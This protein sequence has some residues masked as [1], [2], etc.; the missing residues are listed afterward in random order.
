MT[1]RAS[2]ALSR[3]I[4]PAW[5]PVAC[6]VFALAGLS[7]SDDPVEPPPGP[8]CSY[9]SDCP[10]NDVCFKGT[11]YVSSTCL[12]R[13]Q[14]KRVPVCEGDACICAQPENRCIPVCETDNDC[15]ADG[16]C[17]NGRCMKYPPQ[18]TGT[19][20]GG[21]A[22][23]P[24]EIGVARVDLD[25]PMGVSMAGFATRRGP[26]TP[27]Q[28]SLGGSDA[29][30][31][32]PDV[33]AIAL[34]SGDDLVVL[35]RLPLGW[36][37]ASLL[38]A[39]ALEVQ[40][41]T[42][43]NLID[44]IVTSAPHSHHQPAR[45]W[46][47]VVGLNFGI[48]GYDEFSWE[49]FD[50]LVGSFAD[51]VVAALDARQPGRFGWTVIDDFDPSGKIHRDRRGQ[52]NNLPG[53][54]GKD[55]RML[56]MRFDDLDGNPLALATHFAVHGTIF[57][58]DNPIL[59]G[60]APGGAE[61]TLTREA[62][63]KYGRPVMG[64]FLQGNAGDVSPGGD[65]LDHVEIERLQLV[66]QRAWDVMRDAFDTIE[67]KTDV[68]VDIATGRF[69]VS[70]AALGYTGN[71]FRDDNVVCENT[72]PYFRY[73]SFQCM[74][75]LFKDEDPATKFV[76]GALNCI[77]AVECLTDGYPI[78]QFMKTHLSVLRIGDL[79]LT[80][81]PGEPLS[82]FGMD[83][84][85]AVKAKLPMV[86]DA[87]TLGYSQDHNFYL[88]TEDDW[89]QGGY[90]PSRD[91]WGWKLA[92]YFA[93]KA[94]FLAGELAKP[95][96]E[97][98]IDD[99]NLKPMFWDREA[100]GEDD[101]WVEFTE[102][103]GDPAAVIREVPAAVE[104]LEVV[105]FAWS[106]GH[107]GL[108][109]PRI[110]LE[111]ETDGT[112]APV[113][114]ASGE[115]YA[116]GQFETLVHY[117]GSC[118]REQCRGHRWSVAW[119]EARDF[120]AGRYRLVATGKAWKSGAAVEYT[121]R[122]RAFDLGPSSQLEVYGLTATAGGLEGRVL[123][124]RAIRWA[125]QPDGVRVATPNGHRMRSPLIGSRFAQPLPET[126]LTVTATGSIRLP[127][128]MVQPLSGAVTLAAVPSEARSEIER[129][130]ADGTRVSRDVG[131]KPTTRF[132]LAAPALAQ[133]PAGAYVV[134]LS[135]V[136]QLGNRGT[137]TATITK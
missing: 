6:A 38:T 35:L 133:G 25:F 1:D 132:T 28:V 58:Y 63:K 53:D 121:A 118:D 129:I 123:D 19:V 130:L 24:L 75:G 20:P 51:A 70:R 116:D 44:K 73:G 79:A 94:A 54:T 17:V 87:F 22:R 110:V 16:A 2:G 124:P 61:V 117:E 83:N 120:A 12:E 60:D 66:G 107:P 47:L 21:G 128:G 112:F 105:D 98:K 122:S 89:F 104:R 9:D 85:L 80:T 48:F 137:A 125:M 57:D 126:G 101:T 5:L 55:K 59:T 95:R 41:R 115:V 106:G 78:P 131:L 18:F 77:F 99:Q 111:R 102:T 31:D 68:D 23:K 113:R 92:P 97:R 7:C 50:R 26:S 81:M 109:R 69:P 86:R 29:W 127:S 114:R 119:E 42:G 39:T 82:K 65:D 56:L 11:C 43:L 34:D 90:E 84:A 4:S 46:H 100:L 13:A 62:G 8:A 14:C 15:P 52:N 27:Y 136:D 3:A 33:R 67:T 64:L 76:D 40:K 32:K 135:L 88:T 49:I 108:D 71:Q 10:T 36:S 37:E 45:F 134:R 72:P 30:F 93:D 91:I 103:E 74:E 96:A